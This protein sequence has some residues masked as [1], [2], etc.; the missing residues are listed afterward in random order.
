[1]SYTLLLFIKPEEQLAG[2]TSG[3]RM[4]IALAIV[5]VTGRIVTAN[6]KMRIANVQSVKFGFSPLVVSDA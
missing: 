2:Y 5:T 1:M 4:N 3:N 6:G